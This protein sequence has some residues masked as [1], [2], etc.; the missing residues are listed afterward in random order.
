MEGDLCWERKVRRFARRGVGA[1]PL[2]GGKREQLVRA[3][4]EVL[5]KNMMIRFDENTG[6]MSYTELGRI[7]SHL[8]IQNGTMELF[9]HVST[10]SKRD[11]KEVV[12]RRRL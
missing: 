2:L 7:A 3:A 9:I 1:D 4:C 10:G 11:W 12:P 6:L 8:Y 5:D